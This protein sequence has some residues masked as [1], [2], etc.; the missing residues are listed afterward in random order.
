MARKFAIGT[1]VAG[2]HLGNIF[3]EALSMAKG[4]PSVFLT[5]DNWQGTQGHWVCATF[6]QTSAGAA[7]W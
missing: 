2:I 7:S 1:S 6:S 5:V 3:L 4:F